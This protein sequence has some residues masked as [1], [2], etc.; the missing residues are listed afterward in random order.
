MERNLAIS[1]YP[2]GSLLP[3]SEEVLQ[4][5]REVTFQYTNVADPVERAAR[6]QRVIHGEEQGLMAKTAANIIAAAAAN[7]AP[8]RED[9][10]ELTTYSSHVVLEEN[11]A[12]LQSPTSTVQASSTPRR[13]KILQGPRRGRRPL[14]AL[15]LSLEQVPEDASCLKY[16]LHPLVMA[17]L[18]PLLFC[19]DPLLM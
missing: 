10:T 12:A 18:T 8:I 6:Q 14:L 15:E 1:D 4:E 19:R 11:R 5:L 9:H 2:G 13:E 3:T 17:S 7:L 16:K